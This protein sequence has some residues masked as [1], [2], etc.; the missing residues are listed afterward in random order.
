MF[1]VRGETFRR[2]PGWKSSG[3]AFWK[4]GS[5]TCAFVP[6]EGHEAAAPQAFDEIK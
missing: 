2:W 6:G 3:A 4:T 1:P 5:G